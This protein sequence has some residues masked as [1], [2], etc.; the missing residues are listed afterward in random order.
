M[1]IARG[2]AANVRG[3]RSLLSLE[4]LWGKKR[5]WPELRKQEGEVM[6]L[7]QRLVGLFDIVMTEG[8]E[9]MDHKDIF[10][11]RKREIADR[12]GEKRERGKKVR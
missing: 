9:S 8:R 5:D 3:L 11:A 4:Y 7:V 10:Q 2:Q 1:L 12:R 6:K